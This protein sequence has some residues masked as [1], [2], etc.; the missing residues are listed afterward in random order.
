M[1]PKSRFDHFTC[2]GRR[3]GS[4]LEVHFHQQPSCSRCG[5]GAA[6]VPPRREPD[7]RG[8][9]VPALMPVILSA[10]TFGLSSASAPQPA[11]TSPLTASDC[12]L[13]A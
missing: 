7:R 10:L 4:E 1:S 8:G 9:I 13:A 12:C 6:A 5:C 3:V 11:R 2:W